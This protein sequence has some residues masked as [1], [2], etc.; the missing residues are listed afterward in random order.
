MRF[1]IPM[2]R[3]SGSSALSAWKRVACVLLPLLALPA[4]ASGAEG[5]QATGKKAATCIADICLETPLTQEDI[6]AKYGPGRE[7]VSDAGTPVESAARCYYDP[8]QDLYVEFQFDKHQ[9]AQV[10]FNSD[11]T[12]IM[13]SRAPMCEKRYTPKQPFPKLAT[14]Y[15]LKIGS[16][17]AEVRAAMGTPD[18]MDKAERHPA[19][20]ESHMEAYDAADYGEVAMFY[21]PDKEDLL[22][23]SYY[24]SHGEVKSISLR[25]SE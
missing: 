13:V 6:V 1:Y 16:T 22:S 21:W 7:Q 12:Q 23:N 17:Q 10:T 15:G 4:A 14:E 5:K 20:H 9:Q 24:I 25:F 2:G 11:L 8:A 18:R 3:H 19:S